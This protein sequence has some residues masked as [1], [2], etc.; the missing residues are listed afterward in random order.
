MCDTFSSN[1]KLSLANGVT[2]CAEM[3]RARITPSSPLNYLKE[4]HHSQDFQLHCRTVLPCTDMSFPSLCLIRS[5]ELTTRMWAWVPRTMD[6]QLR[7]PFLR[8]Q[9]NATLRLCIT[10]NLINNNTFLGEQRSRCSA[11]ILV[12]TARRRKVVEVMKAA[13]RWRW[14]MRVSAHFLHMGKG[15]LRPRP[16]YVK[17]WDG[18]RM[19]A[20]HMRFFACGSCCAGFRRCGHSAKV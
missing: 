1:V 15:V 17:L 6:H 12:V 2:R 10:N 7:K 8:Y 16:V 14:T 20:G 19:W 11:E 18:P 5:P 9:Q 13:K 3:R 4:C